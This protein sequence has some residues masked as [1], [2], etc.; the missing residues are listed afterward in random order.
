M[1]AQDY[2]AYL[3][4][5]EYESVVSEAVEQCRA[6]GAIVKEVTLP[7]LYYSVPTYYTICVVEAASNMA[8]YSGLMYGEC[9]LGV[10]WVYVGCMLGV[11]WV[12]VGCMLGVCWV[13]VGCMLGVC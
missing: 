3:E 8:K 13:Y 11:C 4:C 5:P 6:H 7:H 9:V 2:A 12:Y 1:C 10:C